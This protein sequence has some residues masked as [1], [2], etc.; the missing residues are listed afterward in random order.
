MSPEISRRIGAKAAA[1]QL[2]DSC[3]HLDARHSADKCRSPWQWSQRACSLLTPTH[4][5]HT[6]AQAA[7]AQLPDRAPSARLLPW[8][9]LLLQ[10]C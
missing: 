8:L 4:S 9:T 2:P 3:M 1:A 10:A 7:A 6:G 5:R